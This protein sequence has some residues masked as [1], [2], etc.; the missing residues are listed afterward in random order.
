[1]AFIYV[2]AVL[3]ALAVLIRSGLAK[4]RTPAPLAATLSELGMPPDVARVAA[5]LVPVCE[6]AAVASLVAG[7][8]SVAAFLLAM[9]GV[10]FAVAAVVSKLTRQAVRCAC[11]GAS[12]RN[13]GWPQLLALPLWFFS[14]WA[15]MHVPSFHVNDRLTAL[16]YTILILGILQ[17]RKVLI[18]GAS[19]RSDRR[20]FMGG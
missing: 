10:S 14:A 3:A 4:I 16:V 11:F 1:M 20:A 19:A 9:L 18:Q 7:A 5:V 15:V 6:L 8:S 17:A 2:A 12:E 13:L